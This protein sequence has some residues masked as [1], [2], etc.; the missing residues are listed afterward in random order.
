MCSLE[1]P[2]I[3]ASIAEP[4][5]DQPVDVW[6]VNVED[7]IEQAFGFIGEADTTLPGRGSFETDGL[8][9]EIGVT[10]KADLHDMIVTAGSDYSAGFRGQ[11]ACA[12]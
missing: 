12:G 8:S 5:A 1:V 3:Q 2:D 9:V 7:P 11:Y 10:D 6:L 4:F